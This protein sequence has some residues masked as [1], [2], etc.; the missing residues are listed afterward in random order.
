MS[1]PGCEVSMETHPEPAF[2]VTLDGRTIWFNGGREGLFHCNAL[3][4]Q[5]TRFPHASKTKSFAKVPRNQGAIF[6][7]STDDKYTQKEKKLAEDARRLQETLLWPSKQVV[8][9]YLRSSHIKNYGLTLADFERANKNF[10]PPKSILTGKMIAPFQKSGNQTQLSLGLQTQS[11]IKLYV[12]AF[13]STVLL[14]AIASPMFLQIM[15][16]TVTSTVRFSYQQT[17]TFVPKASMCWS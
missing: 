12:D 13:L 15:S 14:L 9:S 17:C 2:L 4:L 3:E 6:V 16:L 5:S 7:T 11:N 1:I 8:V 10:G